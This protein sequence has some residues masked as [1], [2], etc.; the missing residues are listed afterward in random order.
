MY[1]YLQIYLLGS[2]HRISHSNFSTF[3]FFLH[4]TKVCCPELQVTRRLHITFSSLN[5]SKWANICEKNLSNYQ[6]NI[7]CLLYCPHSNFISSSL[8]ICTLEGPFETKWWAATLPSDPLRVCPSAHFS[9][10]F[11][12]ILPFQCFC[13]TLKGST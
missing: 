1:I 2:L 11:N 10:T 12:G 8:I 6:R 4:S 5:K 9:I 7:S 13:G 3:G